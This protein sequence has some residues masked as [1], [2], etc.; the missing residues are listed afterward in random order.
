MAGP[1]NGDRPGVGAGK[2]PHPVRVSRVSTIEGSSSPPAMPGSFMQ[3]IIREH[4]HSPAH[5]FR[6][7]ATNTRRMRDAAIMQTVVSIPL[8][9]FKSNFLIFLHDHNLSL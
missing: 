6:I 1:E 4:V 9:Y 5:P 8:D 7:D 3:R 2:G